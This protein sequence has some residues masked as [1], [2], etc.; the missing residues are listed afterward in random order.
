MRNALR[1]LL[2]PCVAVGALTGC[3]ESVNG[4]GNGNGNGP[5]F[6]EVLVLNSVGKNVTQYDVDAGDLTPVDATI[7]L[8]AN[9]DGDA[10][11]VRNLTLA[12]TVSSFGGSQVI[13]ADITDPAV[14]AIT[15]FSKG[16]LVNP[17]KPAFFQ[18]LQGNLFAVVAGRGT[19]DVWVA[20]P[21]LPEASIV[22][23]SE[24]LGRFVERVLPLSG[25]F[26]LLDANLDDDGEE[27]DGDPADYQPL[28]D[29]RVI[30][31]T[32][33]GDSKSADLAGASNITDALF[34][35]NNMVVLAGGTFG[36]AP[37][38][39]PELNGNLVIV[40]IGAD[41]SPVVGESFPLNGN[42]VTIEPGLDG[43]LYVVRDRGTGLDV[44]TFDG[45]SRDWIRGPENPIQPTDT[46]GGELDCR[47]AIGLSGGRI[48]CAT[49]E[50]AQNGRLILLSAAGEYVAE[51]PA[52]LGA[53]DI[54]FAD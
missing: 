41:N 20:T 7:T 47:V 46:D 16:S 25:G 3:N 14:Q 1:G 51:A 9:F 6:G 19:D 23:D 27:V 13:F 36:P 49:F 48:L 44:L 38:F 15:T 4:N 24:G 2:I 8:P 18:D 32:L 50:A 35:G 17:S 53:T 39:A 5:E 52:G 37:D 10:M 40:T 33:T 26:I 30:T 45:L 34:A 22:G 43:P 42:G 21:G 11:D 29:P 12:T 31:L 54:A 28:G